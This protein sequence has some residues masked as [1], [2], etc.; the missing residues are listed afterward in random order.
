MFIAFLCEHLLEPRPFNAVFLHRRES[1]VLFSF[2][3]ISWITGTTC[4]IYLNVSI[5]VST[6][7]PSSF[8]PPEER[9]RLSIKRSLRWSSK[10]VLSEDEFPRRREGDH[11]PLSFPPFLSTCRLHYV[12]FSSSFHSCFHPIPVPPPA[13]CL[14]Y[15][16]L[17]LFYNFF[18]PFLLIILFLLHFHVFWFL[19]ISPWFSFISGS[20][21]S[22][23]PTSFSPFSFS[24]FYR[25]FLFHIL[26]FLLISSR[27]SP[28][29]SSSLLPLSSLFFYTPVHISIASF[30]LNFILFSYPFPSLGPKIKVWPL[31]WNRVFF[32]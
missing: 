28:I 4:S 6:C 24:L 27:F 2:L 29:S 15:A 22:L 12:R 20:S 1:Q 30:Y 17:P 5:A 11:C 8:A 25:V 14:S 9:E 32:I 26:L 3:L 23:P 18:Q 21:F 7:F 19:F 31:R 16:S 13:A 10:T